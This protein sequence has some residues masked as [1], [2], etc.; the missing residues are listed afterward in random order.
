MGGCCG[1]STFLMLLNPEKNLQL[2]SFL[3]NFYEKVEFLNNQ[4]ID[5]FKWSVA[6]DYL[7]LKSIVD[8]H[9]KN[10]IYFKDPD[11][12]EYYFPIK[13]Y[14]LK[15]YIFSN[16]GLIT[17]KV[18]NY[19]LNKWKTN[20][21]LKILFYLFG[22]TF[23]PQPQKFPDGTGSFYIDKNDVDCNNS[24]TKR[25]IMNEHLIKSNDYEKFCIA[26]NIRSFHWVAVNSV[27]DDIILIND[28]NGVQSKFRFD[29]LSN[30]FRFYFF[31]YD[32]RDSIILN[33]NIIV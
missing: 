2:R 12:V 10:Y 13:L 33:S 8:D 30:Q 19:H 28:P 4:Y 18:F 20:N 11:I 32:L 26:L 16:Y 15:S 25:D 6:I 7:I 22:G 29:N 9:L 24:E 3:N 1:L 23:Y 14:E 5:E 21:D 17:K 27:I 31:S